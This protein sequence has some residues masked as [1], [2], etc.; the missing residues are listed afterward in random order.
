[1]NAIA[2]TQPA[3]FANIACTQSASGHVHSPWFTFPHEGVM[4]Y[5]GYHYQS[6][7]IASIRAFSG[8]LGI[9]V[10]E[11]FVTEKMDDES[12]ERWWRL[13][14]KKPAA[15]PTPKKSVPAGV[16]DV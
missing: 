6:M 16:I 11:V 4:D 12:G 10:Y 9:S 13:G 1:M 15:L 8:A 14:T 3:S 7:R 2:V 5:A